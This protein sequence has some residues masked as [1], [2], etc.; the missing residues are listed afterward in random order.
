V[1]SAAGGNGF[2]IAL[3]LGRGTLIRACICCRKIDYKLF[4]F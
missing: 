4:E 3:S 2:E 1:T